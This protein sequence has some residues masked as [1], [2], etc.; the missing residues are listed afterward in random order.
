[1][2]HE[3]SNLP[4]RL[5]PFQV[6]LTRFMSLAAKMASIAVANV[7]KCEMG[8]VQKGSLVTS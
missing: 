2:T 7:M 5:L 1:M 4:I 3:N 8:N 6:T